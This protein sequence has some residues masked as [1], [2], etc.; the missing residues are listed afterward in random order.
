MKY[1]LKVDFSRFKYAELIVHGRGI[2][3]A[4]STHPVFTTG[5]LPGFV[6]NKETAEAV[7]DKL[8][9][10]YNAS[11]SHDVQKV[12]A[13]KESR[14]ATEVLLQTIA[15]FYETAAITDPHLLNNTGYELR[16]AKNTY[17]SPLEALVS[18]SVSHGKFPGVVIARTA[19]SHGQVSYEVH[20]TDGNPLD[21]NWAFKGVFTRST[22]MEMSDLEGGKVYSFRARVIAGAGAGPW[23]DA[24]SLRAL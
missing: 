8:E 15:R 3:A 22:H 11:L 12:A 13:C 18:L 19:K 9:V 10:D 1:G 16:R 2:I 6:P 7:I 4:M 21:G 20:I 23:S 14:K 5:P 17:A 24:V